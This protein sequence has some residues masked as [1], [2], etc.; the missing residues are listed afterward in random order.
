[1]GRQ[2]YR[3]KGWPDE[4]RQTGVREVACPPKLVWK[5]GLCLLDWHIKAAKI[6]LCQNK[7]EISCPSL[8]TYNF[9]SVYIN[10]GVSR[11]LKITMNVISLLFLSYWINVEDFQNHWIIWLLLWN[12]ELCLEV[13]VCRDNTNTYRLKKKKTL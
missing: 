8:S 3:I 1:M 5:E 10:S 11:R 12:K 2:A 6:R 4:R 7:S 9:I 13:W